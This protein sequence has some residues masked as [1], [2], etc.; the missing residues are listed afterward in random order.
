VS[1]PNT[2]HESGPYDGR[3]LAELLQPGVIVLDGKRQCSF[4]SP[5]ACAHLGASDEAALQRQWERI[6]RHLDLADLPALA[7]GNP[8]VLRRCDVDTSSGTRKLRY[9]L[10]AVGDAGNPHY[11]MLVRERNL[12]DGADRVQ[13]LAS[14]CEATRHVIASLVHDAKG[15][16]N[17]LHL[18]LALLAAVIGKMEASQDISQ[19]LARCRR[20]VDVMQTEETRLASC[21]TD[22]HQLSQPADETADRVDVATLVRDVGQL[23]RHEARIR[24]ANLEVDVQQPAWAFGNRHRLHLA[25]L[26]F[27]AC[28]LGSARSRSS[29]TMRVADGGTIGDVRID[30][31]G[32]DVAMPLAMS[33]AFF[34]LAGVAASDYPSV[35]AGRSII[36]AQG[37]EV[38]LVGDGDSTTGFAITLA[39]AD[40]A[41]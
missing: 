33:R 3:L 7:T 35:L 12:L 21:L 37:G 23:L 1:H 22:I 6:Q 8:P 41:I 31:V 39:R 25:L 29:V 11:V 17:N 38:A 19:A 32:S 15:P 27:C 10:H 13:M 18:T 9:E 2:L 30:I 36:E 24:E 16:L 14:E 28:V 34:R 5:R 20:Y 26:A 40:E 4:A